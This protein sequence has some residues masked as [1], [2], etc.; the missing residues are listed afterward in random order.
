MRAGGV[1][2]PIVSAVH[3]K[4]RIDPQASRKNWR[5]VARH[6]HA[7][8]NERARSTIKAGALG[9]VGAG[10]LSVRSFAS[11]AAA[12]AFTSFAVP[13]HAGV[14]CMFATEKAVISYSL[15]WISGDNSSGV[16]ATFAEGRNKTVTKPPEGQ[17]PSWVYKIDPDHTWTFVSVD[18]LR[19]KI[20]FKGSKE[21]MVSGATAMDLVA[22]MND[23]D[24]AHPGVCE[25]G[26][27]AA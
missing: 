9:T 8:A 27:P 20:V 7:K 2:R 14:L 4:R 22:V 15:G 6:W 21:G 12:F 26:G 5:E 17:R 13:A 19:R 25:I 11:L 23:A 1:C 10:P 3:R 16:Y 24:G 18:D